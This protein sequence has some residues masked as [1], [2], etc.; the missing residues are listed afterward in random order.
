MKAA[1]FDLDGTLLDSMGVWGWVDEVFFARRKM[2]FPPDYGEAVA[3]LNFYDTAMYTI[4]TYQLN[5]TPE[6]VMREW[7]DLAYEAYRDRIELKKGAKEY[8][9]MLK[10]LGV[11]LC[12]A[13]ASEQEIYE[14][15][16]S[17]AGVLDLFDAA[18]LV[19]ET[20]RG[21]E[22]P[23]V[24]ELAAKKLGVLPEEAVVFEDL[25]LAVKGA[26]LGGFRVIGMYDRFAEKKKEEMKALCDRFAMDFGELLADGAKPL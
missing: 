26:K 15:A 13:T 19:S 9:L 14:A 5:E 3:G 25:P 2:P 22:F 7:H 1:I 4:K 21:K 20:A 24:Y 17:R 12:I 8:L 10:A 23:D 16:L 18:A 11:K 6:E